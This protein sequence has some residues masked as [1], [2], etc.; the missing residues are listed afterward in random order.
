M[1]MAW[2]MPRVQPVTTAVWSAREKSSAD[3]VSHDVEC[4]FEW[5]GGCDDLE[6]SGEGEL[7]SSCISRCVGGKPKLRLESSVYAKRHAGRYRR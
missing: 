3:I 1:A 5:E 4:A 6:S 2:P 7:D